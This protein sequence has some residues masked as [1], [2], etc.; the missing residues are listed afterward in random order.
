MTK[1]VVNIDKVATLRNAR[2]GNTPDLLK[3]A[4]DCQTFGAEAIAVHP[5]PD[6]R[7]V[8]YE[9]VLALRNVVCTEF[10]I[11]GY[12]SKEFVE[13]VQK[14]KPTQVTLVPDA[15]DA[16]SSS[17]GWNVEANSD[18]LREVIDELQPYGIRV[19]IFIDANPASVISAAKVGA[20]RVQLFTEPYAALFA[21][22]CQAA[23]APFLNAAKVARETGLGVN[24]GHGLNAQNLPFLHQQID[25]LK[26]VS[27][28]HALIAD[29]LY[30]G[31][32]NAINRYKDCLKDK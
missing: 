11:E 17:A 19:A 24:A 23:I 30:E 18:F 27:V 8:L 5:R 29:A 13:L 4:A 21:Q 20:D 14:A 22:D 31:M 15:P 9:D 28:G 10:H 2:G 25:W 32:E 16:K 12:P 26:E 6:G 1:L 7:H 3:A